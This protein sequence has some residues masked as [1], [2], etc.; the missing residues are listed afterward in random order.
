[1]LVCFDRGRFATRN[2][3]NSVD[4]AGMGRAAWDSRP[5][6]LFGSLWPAVVPR[7]IPLP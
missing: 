7:R 6:E 4:Q 2:S 5:T 3:E 1:M